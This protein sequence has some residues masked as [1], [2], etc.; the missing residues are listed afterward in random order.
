MSQDAESARLQEAGT[1]ETIRSKLTEVVT[2]K[3]PG[4]NGG[5]T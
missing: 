2:G 1:A 4:E 3:N 5:P